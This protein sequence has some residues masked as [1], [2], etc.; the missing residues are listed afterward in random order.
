MLTYLGRRISD[1]KLRL[2]GCAGCRRLWPF[3][4][5]ERSRKAVEV[6]ERYA[7]GLASEA[8]LQAAAVLAQEAAT[9]LQAVRFGANAA[10]TAAMTTQTAAQAAE[11]AAVAAADAD[12]LRDLCGNPFRAV[13]LDPSWLS[14]NDG[15]VP[16]MAQAIYEDRLFKDLPILADA[17]EEAGCNR[18]DLLLHC[19]L[20]GLHQRGC[21]VLDLLL[22]KE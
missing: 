13:R 11:R 2:Y 15:T 22:G 6:S 21:W 8:E 9:A 17:L 16:K 7:D 10:L 20:P 12:M 14:W 18:A 19:R 3:L 1:R 4:R 5:D